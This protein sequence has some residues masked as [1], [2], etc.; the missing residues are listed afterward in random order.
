MRSKAWAR[1]L[2]PRGA[3]E[4]TRRPALAVERTTASWPG[5]YGSPGAGG[6][7]AMP[8]YTGGA[9]HGLEEDSG[10]SFEVLGAYVVRAGAWGQTGSRQN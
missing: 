6:G 2:A 5:H 9:G 7:L 10:S 3:R 8:G 1:R 4:P